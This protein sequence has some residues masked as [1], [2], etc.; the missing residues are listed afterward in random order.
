MCSSEA[1]CTKW[2]NQ[3]EYHPSV[4]IMIH[5]IDS[6]SLECSNCW[7]GNKHMY[8]LC[9][10][11]LSAFVRYST[12]VCHCA[13][14]MIN[15]KFTINQWYVCLC[16]HQKVLFIFDTLTC[17]YR[18]WSMTNAHKVNC[19]FEKQRLDYVQIIFAK[20]V[21]KLQKAI[22]NTVLLF[23]SSLIHTINCVHAIEE[24]SKM[25]NFLRLLWYC[26]MALLWWL[27]FV[28]PINADAMVDPLNIFWVLTNSSYL[29]TYLPRVYNL[30]EATNI[31]C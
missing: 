12:L 19:K 31:L 10:F 5:L 30:R 29:G 11:P 16:E 14:C 3:V 4:N 13:I 6:Y 22:T 8:D 21:L 17:L 23:Q 7:S 28:I 26:A 2:I 18:I 9:R 24:S 1:Q 15:G 27:A 25:G 20:S